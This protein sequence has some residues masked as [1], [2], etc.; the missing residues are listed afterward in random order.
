MPTPA[1]KAE[2]WYRGI[3]EAAARFMVGWREPEAE[4]SRQCRASAV[5]DVQGN[6]ATGGVAENTTKGMRRGGGTGG[7]ERKLR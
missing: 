3:L 2:K 6:G 1:K 5:G 7:V 4:M